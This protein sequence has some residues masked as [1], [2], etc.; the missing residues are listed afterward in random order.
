MSVPFARI[1]DLAW[2][3]DGSA[4]VLFAAK[5][6]TGSLGSLVYDVYTVRPDGSGVKRLTTN[7]SGWPR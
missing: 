3:A 4:L 5:V 1:D 2:L 6:D 7:V